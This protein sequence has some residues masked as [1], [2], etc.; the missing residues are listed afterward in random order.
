MLSAGPA[1]V[2]MVCR[3]PTHPDCFPRWAR[4]CYPFG[5][6]LTAHPCGNDGCSLWWTVDTGGTPGGGGSDVGTESVS[7]SG[8]LHKSRR[9]TAAAGPCPCGSEATALLCVCSPQT[10]T[11]TTQHVCPM[12]Q[13]SECCS[14]CT[15]PT[16]L[17]MLCS[18]VEFWFAHFPICIARMPPISMATLMHT[19]QA[20]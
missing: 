12:F 2:V 16:P 6:P 14:A 9:C 5:A 18:L 15:P 19:F 8:I 7:M 13:T 20:P 11:G 4:A 17:S 3:E 10:F 1:V